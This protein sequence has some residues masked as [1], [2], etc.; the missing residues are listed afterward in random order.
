[1]IKPLIRNALAAD[2]PS[3]LA[4]NA[5]AVKALSPL[6]AERLSL[7]HT[8]CCYLRV[9]EAQGQEQGQLL[10]FLLAFQE[11]SAYD[12]PNYR[13]FANTYLRFCYIDRIVIAPDQQGR[14]FAKALYLDLFAS[15]A[16]LY[17]DQATINV[18]LEIDSE[19]PNPASDAFHARM[20]FAPVGVQSVNYSQ[21]TT[22]GGI[23]ANKAVSL[24]TLNLS[25]EKP[26]PTQAHHA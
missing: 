3:V 2:F 19:P 12:S 18:C 24:Q 22:Q 5:A 25:L 13:W 16:V 17:P 23:L 1:M 14:G 9:I 21:Y 20:G 15:L 7:L 10:G 11:G 6:S 4:L 8:Q 26:L